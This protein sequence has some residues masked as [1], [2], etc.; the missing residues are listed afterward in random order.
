MA[1]A[2]KIIHYDFNDIRYSSF[3]LTG[4]Q[5]NA[6][7]G[8]YKFVVS[9]KAPS[10]LSD[11]IMGDE[12]KDILFSICLFKAKLLNEEFYFC[13]DTRDSCEA[14]PQKGRGYHLPLLKKVKYYFK[15]NY[16]ADA[17]NR[18]PHLREFAGKIIPG[19]PFFPIRMPKIL[20]FLPWIT[21][22]SITGWTMQ[23]ALNRVRKL[24][25]L[26]TL[27]RIKQFRNQEK[28]LDIFFVMNFY[29]QEVH[30]ADN[31]LRYQIMKEIQK[32]RNI[33]SIFGFVGSTKLP[34]KFAEFQVE[35]YPLMEYLRHLA[36][37]K[38]A[39]YMRGLHNCFSFK[40]PQLLALGMPIVGQTIPNNCDTLYQH[41]YFRDQFAFNNPE[42]IVRNAVELLD[43]LEKRKV[44][45]ESNAEVFDRNFTPQAAVFDVI[46]HLKR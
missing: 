16:N 23:N 33:T 21:P 11:P 35:R 8:H 13:I 26:V 27:E 31:E 22:S 6:G 14:N 28:D 10:L 38:V 18:D 44:L 41:E 32:Y 24:K 19:Y 45:S 29:G 37:S 12:W 30:A 39:I 34:A 42:E 25:N 46:E 4:F 9:K 7:R 40:F 2:N 43:D 3:F 5:Q 15:V 17:I 1:E 36:R 20:S